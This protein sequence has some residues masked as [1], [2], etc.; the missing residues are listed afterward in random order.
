METTEIRRIESTMAT[1]NSSNEP[2]INRTRVTDGPYLD[3]VICSLCRGVAWIPII[4]HNCEA[5]YCSLCVKSH[6]ATKL[7][8]IQCPSKCSGFSKGRCSAVVFGILSKL[9][10]TCRNQV[11]GCE[12]IVHYNSLETHEEECGYRQ[13]D[14]SGCQNQISKKDFNDHF[15]TCPSVVLTCSEC[16]ADYR[17]KDQDGH[18]DIVCIRAQLR[19]HKEQI[20]RLEKLTNSSKEN[21]ET[22]QQYE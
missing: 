3:F 1:S 12:E 18:T 16:N 9:N 13:K 22:F 20:N 15:G 17:R 19:Q 8:P 4:C 10:V 14:C 11:Y 21:T 2:Y 7:D 6:H 5:L